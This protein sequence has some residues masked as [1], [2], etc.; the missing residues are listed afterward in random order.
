MNC[1]N[2]KF[3][4]LLKFPVDKIE[5]DDFFQIQFIIVDNEKSRKIIAK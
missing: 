5:P 1:K 3:F 2:P 4:Q